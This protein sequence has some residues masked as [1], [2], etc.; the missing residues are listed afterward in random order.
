M[1]ALLPF[2]MI[3]VLGCGSGAERHTRPKH[4]QDETPAVAV[5]F[6]PD[7][8]SA[9][10]P[11]ELRGFCQPPA[12]GPVPEP[13]P[14]AGRPAGNRDSTAKLDVFRENEELGPALR[15][16][17]TTEGQARLVR[18]YSRNAG[19]LLDR[20]AAGGGG[21]VL[22]AWMGTQTST[23]YVIRFDSVVIRG[24]TIT[25]F[26]RSMGPAGDAGAM[27]TNPF[28]IARLHRA[29]GPVEFVEHP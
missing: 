9:D 18:G 28:A 14:L 15:C 7:G 4:A 16:V 1:R 13:R 10:V 20:L 22:L 27:L 3:A 24:D 6:A 17:V 5:P 21:T 12:G 25:A 26:V 8:A 11:R 23:G 29:P 2:A 19:T